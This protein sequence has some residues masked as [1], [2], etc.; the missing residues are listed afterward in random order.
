MLLE[1]AIPF[2]CDGCRFCM[3]ESVSRKGVLSSGCIAKYRVYTLQEKRKMSWQERVLM[4]SRILLTMY[5]MWDE[6]F[7]GESPKT[8]DYR[9]EL[10]LESLS[11]EWLRDIA[12]R[13]E[14]LL[15]NLSAMQASIITT[16]GIHALWD[17]WY[18]K[19]DE[20]R[21]FFIRRQ[22]RVA[23]ILWAKMDAN[24]NTEESWVM[25]TETKTPV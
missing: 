7:M 21:S 10:A 18:G 19:L 23:A 25:S 14:A 5:S 15:K 16:K 3:R 13:L 8:T 1:R 11:V 9:W 6:V 2:L 22:S 24:W 12:H 20:H 17:P 4:M